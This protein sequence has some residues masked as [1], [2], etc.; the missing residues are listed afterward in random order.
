MPQ[1]LK[2]EQAGFCPR[3]VRRKW[4]YNILFCFVKGSMTA[5]FAKILII[6]LNH[7]KVGLDNREK[8]RYNSVKHYSGL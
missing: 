8:L 7:G 6:S 4:Q 3:P 5:F 2:K 1:K